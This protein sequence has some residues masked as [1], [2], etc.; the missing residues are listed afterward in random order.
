MSLSA[1]RAEQLKLYLLEKIAQKQTSIVRKTAET[2]DVTLATVYRYLDRLERE[3]I[4]QKLKRDQYI[5]I[6]N[7][8]RFLL[9]R[10]SPIFFSKM[11]FTGNMCARI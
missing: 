3:G 10:S 9:D 2:F 1:E 6:T 4:I 5:L 7:T 11:P 8:E